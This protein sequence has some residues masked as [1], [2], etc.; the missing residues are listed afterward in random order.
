M[1]D[2]SIDDATRLASV[3]DEMVEREEP[4]PLMVRLVLEDCREV[5]DSYRDQ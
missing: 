1:R 4:F 3:I 5:R 2:A